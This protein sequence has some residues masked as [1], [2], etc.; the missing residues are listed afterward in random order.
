MSADMSAL[1]DSGERVIEERVW[2]EREARP[3]SVGIEEF[4]TLDACASFCEEV[5]ATRVALQ[6]PDELLGDAVHVCSILQQRLGVVVFILGDTS[7][8]SCCVDDV[9]AQHMKADALVH[10]GFA[11]LSRATALPVFY[12]FGQLPL[13][14]S[15]VEQQ[16]QKHALATDANAITVL[17][18]LRYH[19]KYAA[20]ASMVARL[21]SQACT[22]TLASACT[23]NLDHVETHGCAGFSFPPPAGHI[24]YI[25]QE[26][27]PA[28]TILALTFN[29]LPVWVLDPQGAGEVE[30]AVPDRNR[31]LMRRYYLVQKAKDAAII[32]IVAGTLGVDGY[33][34][35]LDRARRVIRRAGKTSYTVAVGKLNDPKL[36]NFADVDIFVSIACPFA[37]LYDTWDCVKDII[38]PFELELALCFSWTG[39]YTT[40]FQTV[41]ASD[42]VDEDPNEPSISP[43]YSLVSRSLHARSS[44]SSAVARSEHQLVDAASRLQL[45]SY[46]GLDPQL[47]ATAPS[48]VKQGL[49]GIARAYE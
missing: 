45:H 48:E 41:L 11:C 43:R 26:S 23:T 44:A 22:Y 19:H 38:T 24:V 25:G 16:L 39:A 5:R 35:A 17:Y 46:R 34:D 21:S 1:V 32:G 36:A 42:E 6:F 49:S 8:G 40:D 10:F 3:R 31:R 30:A 28:L 2:L 18:D 33:R 7:Y 13:A 12:A 9:A 4:Y 14:I 20:M 27:H 15:G 47:G 37:S 29:Q